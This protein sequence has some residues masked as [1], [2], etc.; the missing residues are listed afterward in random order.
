MTDFEQIV[1]DGLELLNDDELDKH[2]STSHEEESYDESFGA[3]SI[4]LQFSQIVSRRGVLE[5]T[6]K[7]LRQNR[8][9]GGR[10][11]RDRKA[12]IDARHSMTD[13]HQPLSNVSSIKSSKQ[14]LNNSGAHQHARSAKLLNIS[15]RD[16]CILHLFL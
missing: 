15:A 8:R 10:R 1:I 6:Q 12:I 16:S 13:D 3:D 9:T 11:P 4:D 14:P 7:N 2:A 5:S